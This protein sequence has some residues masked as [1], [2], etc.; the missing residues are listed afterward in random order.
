MENIH[1]KIKFFDPQIDV[2][3]KLVNKKFQ[4]IPGTK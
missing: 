4:Y 2:K 3:K 1:K